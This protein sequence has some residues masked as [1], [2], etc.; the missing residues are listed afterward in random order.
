MQ[1]I[2]S[3]SEDGMEIWF[4]LDTYEDN[5]GGKTF[6]LLNPDN[7]EHITKLLANA[8]NYRIYLNNE[9]LLYFRRTTETQVIWADADSAENATKGFMVIPIEAAI[10]FIDSSI[11]PT[12]VEIAVKQK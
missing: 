11:A 5:G 9:E 4:R 6:V 2:I 3:S 12:S 8:E 10:T 1:T 7:T